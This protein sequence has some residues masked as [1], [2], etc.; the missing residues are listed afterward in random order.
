MTAPGT[1]N[2]PPP[3]PPPA[4]SNPQLVILVHG[5]G[6]A[7]P[8][9]RGERWWQL[10]SLFVQT[11]AS[12]LSGR[13]SAAPPFHWSG[14]N[15][16]LARRAAAT[17]LLARLAEYEAAGE[18]YHLIG[19]S[20]GGSV[21]WHALVASAQQ[22]QR[23]T[24]LQSWATVGTPFLSFRAVAPSPWRIVAMALLVGLSLW[25]WIGDAPAEWIPALLRAQQE[26]SFWA[27]GAVGLIFGMLTFL[28][29]WSIARVVGPLIRT[30]RATLLD[31]AES[32][33][34]DWY[35][36]QWLALWHPLD[37]P[38]NGL[39]GTVGPAPEIAPRIAV[40][41]LLNLVPFAAWTYNRLLARATDEF[42]W[43]AIMDRAQGA[44]LQGYRLAQVSRAPA[45]MQGAVKGLS[46]EL[47]DELTA[48]AD[49]KA[50]DS[51]HRLRALLES[52]YD[53]QGSKVLFDRISS[54]VSF[55][56]IIHTS[57]F[58]HPALCK[59]LI[60]HVASSLR[61][62]GAG[63]PAMPA[64]PQDVAIGASKLKSSPASASLR[65]AGR[66]TAAAQ[67]RSLEAVTALTLFVGP[68]LLLAL[69]GASAYEAVIAPYTASYQVRQI[70]GV[71][72]DPERTHVSLQP[73]VGNLIKRLM[74]LGAIGD[75][76]AALEGIADTDARRYGAPALAHGL[77]EGSR[78][79]DVDRLAVSQRIVGDTL[80]IST[81]AQI[82]AAAMLGAMGRKLSIP[83]ALWGELQ[84]DL[85]NSRLP[86]YSFVDLETLARP[87]AQ[88]I[89][90]ERL[91]QMIDAMN[92][93]P[94]AKS[95][96]IDGTEYNKHRC[97]FGI[98]ALLGA[99]AAGRELKITSTA[100][101]CETGKTLYYR[102]ADA[103]LKKLGTASPE[104][105]AQKIGQEE[106]A[107]HSYQDLKSDF[108]AFISKRLDQLATTGQPVLLYARI[109]SET[110]DGKQE[111]ARLVFNLQVHARLEIA[112]T[113]KSTLDRFITQLGITMAPNAYGPSQDIPLRV[114]L[115]VLKLLQVLYDDPALVRADE[116]KTALSNLYLQQF[117]TMWYE[118]H[119]FITD[120][121][122]IEVN[123]YREVSDLLNAVGRQTEA[124]KLVNDIYG[125]CINP[126]PNTTA[127][128]RAA[129][130]I[131]VAEA[132]DR[133]QLL[134]LRDQALKAS[135]P[136][137]ERDD[138]RFEAAEL[139]MLLLRTAANFRNVDDQFTHTALKAVERSL[140]L[141]SNIGSRSNMFLEL[142]RNWIGRGDLAHARALADKATERATTLTAYAEILD[143]VI[144]DRSL[145]TSGTARAQQ[146]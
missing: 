38:I 142:A 96:D 110:S 31:R 20:H 126:P 3:V 62:A 29:G 64:L 104:Q 145:R 44:D 5:T 72:H 133:R 6:A 131:A 52:A 59:L 84:T 93:S 85:T 24:G 92:R 128:A 10:G 127:A 102:K 86:Y 61:T 106:I 139:G 146:P 141:T 83:P 4:A 51:V 2:P 134:P 43:S 111:F 40:D 16:E 27:V 56:E 67:L 66:R 74:L 22:G 14:A 47:A 132:A 129:C 34:C 63:N 114:K 121:R 7:D 45:V 98:G 109:N 124:L 140:A 54:V 97:R 68:G 78:W 119:P 79:T 17:K 55:Q 50:V 57:Y 88:D 71:L 75:P 144:A 37:E 91:E 15:S 58:D 87:M 82:R 73:A 70:A 21:I 120:A 137:L 130:Y 69:A 30:A 26:R 77:G 122:I 81:A 39:A 49:S 99:I 90:F 101:D 112:L 103:W 123:P 60:E 113:G 33:A 65:N 53:S 46:T 125:R 105:I 12:A 108:D 118:P 76:I 42:A 116:T 95:N 100:T 48:S 23:L 80:Y 138:L 94:R 117:S 13:A 143:K 19:H 18:R 36:R 115:L 35:G 11:L 107:R 8:A 28:T 32:R 1:V 89:Y 135:L 9:D 136:L 41:G 25:L